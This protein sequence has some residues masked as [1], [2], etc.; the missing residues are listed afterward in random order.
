[1]MMALVREI[2]TTDWTV[3]SY[4]GSVIN[5]AAADWRAAPFWGVIFILLGKLRCL[6]LGSKIKKEQ[7]MGGPFKVSQLKVR[8]FFDN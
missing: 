7:R 1:M 2:Q 3:F 4:L 8:F 5:K 6:I